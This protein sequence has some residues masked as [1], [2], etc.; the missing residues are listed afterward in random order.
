MLKEIKNLIEKSRG[1]REQIKEELDENKRQELIKE[2]AKLYS[3]LEFLRGLY[4]A[5]YN[6]E[7]LEKESKSL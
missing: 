7:K 2:L 1:L 6:A 5:K 4:S 3:K